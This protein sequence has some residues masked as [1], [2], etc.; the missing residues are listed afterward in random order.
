MLKNNESNIIIINKINKLN[1]LVPLGVA[2][3][4]VEKLKKQL[5]EYI[6]TTKQACFVDRFT[7]KLN[8]QQQGTKD[9][10]DRL[11]SRNGFDFLYF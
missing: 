7:A 8:S 2:A 10:P 6:H 11:C 5:L 4:I 3:V 9:R 1:E